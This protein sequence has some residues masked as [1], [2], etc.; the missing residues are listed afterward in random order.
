MGVGKKDAIVCF[1]IASEISL[2]TGGCNVAKEG[3][4]SKSSI[5]A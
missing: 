5:V 3:N 1:L 2:G 4:Y